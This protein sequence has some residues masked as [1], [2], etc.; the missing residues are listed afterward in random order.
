M[1]IAFVAAK[2]LTI[3]PFGIMSLIPY[4]LR[5]GHE[6]KLLEAEDEKVADKVRHFRPTIVGY[7]VCTGAH[8]Y[9]AKLNRYLKNHHD[10]IAV[11]G[12]PH[13]TFFPD[14]LKEEGIDA[15]CRGEGDLAFSE[16][17]NKVAAGG[18]TASVANFSVKRDGKI[19]SNPLRPLVE[20]LDTLPFVDRGIYYDVHPE[21]RRHPVRSFLA[22]RGCRFVCT[23][24]FNPALDKLYQGRWRALRVRSPHSLIDEIASVKNTYPTRFIAFR[25]SVFPTEHDWLAVFAAD[26]QKRI[27]LPFY[28]HLRLDLLTP[29]SV[30]LL[31]KAGCHSVNVGIETGSEEKRARLLARPMSDRQIID[32]CALLRKN[33]IKVLANNMLGLPGSDFNDELKTLRLNR[34]CKVTYALAML[35][36]PY[37]GTKLGDDA[38]KAGLFQEGNFSTVGFSYYLKSPLTFASSLQK[39]RVENLQKL[40]AVAVLAPFLTPLLLFVTRLPPN[41]L[42]RT[43]FRSVYFMFHST[44]I[45]PVATGFREWMKIF[46]HIAKD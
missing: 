31:R 39:R 9:Y 7:S 8:T 24:C 21:I 25:E 15:L 29:Q 1:K 45:F 6:V 16:F 22:A 17:C 33:K 5:D 27:G 41:R 42:F 44:E 12:G 30:E 35:W 13:P 2:L 20:N 23:Y 38:V 34:R 19:G 36:Q 3:E 40:F 46:I 14:Y 4:L 18:D 26:Y 28:C 37:P 11:A 10:F 43:I 32:G